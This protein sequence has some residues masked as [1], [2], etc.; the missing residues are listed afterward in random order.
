MRKT[1]AKRFLLWWPLAG[2]IGYFFSAGYVTVDW[3][4]VTLSVCVMMLV[5]TCIIILSL[6][7][8]PRRFKPAIFGLAAG[9]LCIAS[10]IATGVSGFSIALFGGTVLC[11]VWLWLSLKEPEVS[12]FMKENC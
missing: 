8:S 2:F 7:K 10:L 4:L 9:V 3:W 11:S 1:T 12:T 5:A 6:E